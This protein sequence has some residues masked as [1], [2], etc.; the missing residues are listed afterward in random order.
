MVDPGGGCGFGGHADGDGEVHE[1]GVWADGSR[2]RV[3]AGVGAEIGWIRYSMRQ[4]RV[5]K[6]F[7]VFL[8]STELL[9]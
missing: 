6:S 9:K 3:E 2:G 4:V 1:R 7:C 5:L 8:L